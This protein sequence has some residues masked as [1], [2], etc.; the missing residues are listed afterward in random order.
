HA[1]WTGT[2]FGNAV[3]R[4]LQRVARRIVAVRP[5]YQLVGGASVLAVS[6]DQK[7]VAGGFDGRVFLVE[8]ATGKIQDGIYLGHPYEI[9]SLCFSPSGRYL[10]AAS[11]EG[12]VVPRDGIAGDLLLYDLL[13]RQRT[14]RYGSEMGILKAVFFPAEDAVA[15]VTEKHA[16][17]FD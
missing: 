1:D 3:E 5:E 17:R 8:L 12:Q 10:C 13:K 11:A 9:S 7:L 2:P 6:P 15:V 14:F 4:S 16:F